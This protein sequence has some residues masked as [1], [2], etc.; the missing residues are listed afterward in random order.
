MQPSSRL[1]LDVPPQPRLGVRARR[2]AF[3]D[4]GQT[5]YVGLAATNP[6]FHDLVGHP[7]LVGALT[8]LMDDGVAFISDK[9]V[10]KSAGKTFPTPWHID[11]F[12][13]P[14]TRAKLSLWLALDDVGVDDGA[15]TVVAGSH[16]LELEAK[17]GDLAHTNNE[18][19]HVAARTAWRVEDERA[20]PIPKGAGIFFSDRLVHGSTPSLSGRD[21]WA[22]IGTYQ[23]PGEDEA[24]DLDF[25]A[26]R[27]L[28]PARAALARR[29]P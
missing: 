26:R 4:Q 10:F 6:T 23:A 28:V 9:L 25:P 14:G 17:P 7:R 15:L 11:R 8:Q 1:I 12:Y 19:H 22:W 13:W 27:V 21:R 29:C 24:W 18:F 3:R 20:V 2:R 5:V 16:R